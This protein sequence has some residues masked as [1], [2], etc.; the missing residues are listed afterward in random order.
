VE[1]V[2]VGRRVG[3]YCTSL[4]EFVEAGEERRGEESSDKSGRSIT[5]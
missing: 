2:G 5:E 1:K 4:V 3:S